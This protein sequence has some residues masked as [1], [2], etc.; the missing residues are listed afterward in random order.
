[1]L[2][3]TAF[4]Q[5]L[6]EK[7]QQIDLQ[8]KQVE[9][10]QLNH[11]IALPAAVDTDSTGW[12]PSP[13]KGV[14]RLM[15][16]REGGEQTV[17]ATS[18][19]AYAAGSQF[20]PHT[21]PKGEEFFVLAGTF[22]DEGGDYPTGTYVRNPPGSSHKPFSREGCLIWVKLQQFEA[23]D[24]Q[25]VVTDVTQ[26]PADFSNEYWSKKVLFKDYETVA[27]IYVRQNFTL[28]LEWIQSG[29]EILVLSGELSDDIRQYQQGHWMRFPANST[30]TLRANQSSQ[31]LIK[32]GHL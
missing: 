19:V 23:T 3:A 13:A 15:L 6:Y 20:A 1:M 31:F 25:H 8:N 29:A 4:W 22:S 27:M 16:E 2:T 26:A 11:N 32:Y 30:S 21:H 28:P 14:L 12:L 9:H 18:I 5:H 7:S 24:S 10:I 17:R